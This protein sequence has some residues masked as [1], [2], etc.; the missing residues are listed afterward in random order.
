VK[1]EDNLLFK[2][3]W[4]F[5]YFLDY[6]FWGALFVGINRKWILHSIGILFITFNIK[7]H[8]ISFLQV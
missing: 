5:G 2:I 7:L 3:L 4:I 8:I 1:I 6:N